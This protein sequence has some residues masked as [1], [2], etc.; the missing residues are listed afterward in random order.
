MAI[1]AHTFQTDPFFSDKVLFPSFIS[2]S[3]SN[4]LSVCPS[5]ILLTNA[6]YFAKM[7]SPMLI[8][9]GWLFEVGIG[10]VHFSFDSLRSAQTVP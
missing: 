10:F 2:F 7:F 3:S 9:F 6:L 5:Y 8:G 1:Y 4:N